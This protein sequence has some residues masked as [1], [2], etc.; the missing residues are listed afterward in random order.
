MPVSPAIFCKR[1]K[2]SIKLK[3]PVIG[4][5]AN[6]ALKFLIESIKVSVLPPAASTALPHD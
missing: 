6:L 2:G 4:A 5:L 1:A 3:S